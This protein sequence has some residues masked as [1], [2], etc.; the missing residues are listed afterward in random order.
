MRFGHSFAHRLSD[1]ACVLAPVIANCSWLVHVSSTVRYAAAAAR[2]RSL[3]TRTPTNSIREGVLPMEPPPLDLW[4]SEC[5]APRL[6]HRP[7]VGHHSGAG[8][9]GGRRV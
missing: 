9:P 6:E 2:S 7:V 4:E 3:N 5:A 8:D 1:I